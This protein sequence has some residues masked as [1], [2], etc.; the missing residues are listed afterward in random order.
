MTWTFKNMTI[1]PAFVFIILMALMPDKILANLTEVQGPVVWTEPAFPTKDDDITLYFDASEGNGALAGLDENVYAH[2]G[3]IT[4]SSSS[5]TDWKYVI[6][7]WGTDDSRTL[8]TKDSGD[9]YSI[10]YNIAD[11]HNLPENEEVLKLAF[12]F[13]NLSGSIVGRA[14]DGGDIFLDVFQSNAGLQMNVISPGN[15]GQVLLLGEDL[16][17]E[18]FVS[19]TAEITILDNDTEI[20]STTGITAG[21]LHQPEGLGNHQLTFTATDQDTSIVK[22]IDYLLIDSISIVSEAPEGVMD[23]LNYHTDSSYVF[24]LNAPNKKHVFLLTYANDFAPDPAY[25]MHV[26]PDSETFWIELPKR[27]FVD[28]QCAYQYLVDGQIRVAD[29]YSEVVLDPFN[30]EFVPS[31]VLD[32]LAVYPE[33]LASGIV[34]AFDQERDTLPISHIEKPKQENLVIYEILMRDFLEDHNFQTLLD[35]LPYLARLGVNAIELMPIN[36]FEGNQSWGYNPSFHMAVDKYYGSRKDLK[37]LISVA[38]DMGIAVILDVVFNHA[39]SQSPI[40]QLYWDPANFIPSAEN[41]WLN[42]QAR[43]PFNV[44]YDFNHEYAG[45][46]KWVKRILSYWLQEFKFDGFRFDLSK[47]L[48]QFNSGSNAALMSQYDASR[49]AILKEYADHIWE[50]DSS[51]YVV[52]EHFADN[53]E[54]TELANYGMM[55]WGNMNHAFIESAKGSRQ[56]LEWADYTVRGWDEPNLISYMESHDEER[57]MY[58]IPREGDAEEGY[59]TRQFNT[60]IQRVAAASTIYFTIPGPKMI[61]QFG[62]FGYDFSINRCINGSVDGCRLDPKPIRWDYALDIQRE[63]LFETTR[64]L[65]H[66]RNTYPTFTSRDFTFDDRNQFIKSV[67][68]RHPEM[69]AMSLVNFTVTESNVI[70]NFPYT[71]TWYEYFSGDSVVV[72]D[73][74]ERIILQPGAYHIYTSKPISTPEGFVTSSR[75]VAD[76]TTV[77]LFPNPTNGAMIY[78]ELPTASHLDHIEIFS[79]D[80]RKVQVSLNRNGPLVKISLA[81]NLS[82]GIYFLKAQG[83]DQLYSARFIVR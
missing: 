42:Q 32:E 70:P 59:S 72:S 81:D 6:G 10:T 65:I 34:T 52:M 8:M 18:V 7:N 63:K 20:F 14:S 41:P 64:A 53:D 36:E 46:K 13:R 54:E 16:P 29:P 73:L 17:I 74:E 40:A 4:S 50:I 79:F 33:G 27:L 21:L 51:A 55:L 77:K 67:Q 76:I 23:G 25:Q 75:E 78:I 58:R 80:G 44:G 11:F 26:T 37:Q 35:T 24:Q 69:D 15:S 48:T 38:H 30:D 56:K 9:I 62:E 82:A 19:D 57:M 12:V 1:V 43:H 71:G 83:D 2:M 61:W 31:Y 49:V 28:N 68:L 60:A 39:F 47:G 45:T 22:V 66:L 3:L 5:A